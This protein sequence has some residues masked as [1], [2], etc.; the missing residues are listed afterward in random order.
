MGKFPILHRRSHGSTQPP[1]VIPPARLPISYAKLLL[2]LRFGQVKHLRQEIC[3]ARD[4][5]TAQKRSGD[6]LHAALLCRKT[7]SIEFNQPFGALDA[8]ALAC[9]LECAFTIKDNLPKN[10]AAYISKMPTSLRNLFLADIKIV[11][12]LEQMIRSSVIRYPDGVSQAVNNVWAEAAGASRTFEAWEFQASPL[13][14]WAISHSNP[15]NGMR[16]QRVEFDIFEGTLYIDGQILGRLPDEYT[17]QGFFQRMFGNRV[18]L[19]YPSSITGMSYML[20]SLYEDHEIHFGFRDGI[21]IVR[22]RGANKTLEHIPSSVFI[23]NDKGDA[24]DL[25]MPL[26]IDRVHWLNLTSR[27]LEIRPSATMWK[28]K[29]SD[30]TIDLGTNRAHRRESQLI[31]PRSPIFTRVASIIE[32]FEHKS[33]MVIY[34]PKRSGISVH[35]PSLELLFAINTNGLLESRQLRAFIDFDQDAGTLYGLGSS[36]VLRDTLIPT[37][38]SIIVAMGQANIDQHGD[39]ARIHINHTGYYARFSI[40]KVL[41]RLECPPEPR[42]I[43]F[44]AYCHAVTSFVLPDPL[45]G[46][47]GVDEAIH[48]LQAGNAQPW[49]PLDRPEDY[50]ILVTISELT[51]QRRYYPEELKVIQRVCWREDLSTTVQHDRFRSLVCSNLHT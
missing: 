35:L 30:W 27:S 12:R 6:A 31:D 51:P 49:A 26:I 9:F 20:A 19:T 37:D 41:G 7:F 32:P 46:R 5:E 23:G 16:K 4:I 22:A 50:R 24:P 3:N 48:C 13:D 38:R 47:T 39:H 8:D 25:P 14:C 1:I 44:K 18:F 34:Q 45:T 10:D 29:S 40:N 11:S 17:K 43:Y 15:T 21:P 36:L 28:S 33:S 2:I 42:L